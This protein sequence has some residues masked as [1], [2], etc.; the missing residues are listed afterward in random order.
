M[1]NKLC[2]ILLLI[3][4][5][6][7]SF[8]QSIGKLSIDTIDLNKKL[9]SI[10]EHVAKNSPGCAVTIIENGK[11]I[12]RRSYGMANIENQVPFTHQ[13][14]LRMPYSEARE[15]IS[16]ALVLM[17]KDGILSLND[18]VGKYYPN[19]PNWSESV[20]L[21][22]LLNHRSGFVDEWATL[23]LMY[24][25][26]SNRFETDQFLR[27]LYN[28]SIP[29]VEPGKG[30][31]YCNSDFGLLRLIME[32]ACSKD[33]PSWVSKRIFEPLKMVSTHMQKSPLDIIPNR[34]DMYEEATGNTFRQA[35]VQKT[36]PGGN[37]YI[38]TSANDLE[39]WAAAVNDSAS[40]VSEAIQKLK[41]NV[42]QI[43]GKENHFVFGY[44]YRAVGDSEVIL[45]EG[46]NGFNYL[47]RIPSKGISV[48]TLGNK[49]GDGFALENKAIINYLLNPPIEKIKMVKFLTK[50]I[51]IS[52]SELKKYTG[53]FLWQNQI[54]WEGTNKPRKFSTL[55]MDEGKLM[56][57][58]TGN[59]VL[60]LIPVG[61]DIFYYRE[62]KDGF[63]VQL[64]FKKESEGSPLVL[65]VSFDD[66][67]P[68]NSMTR[69]TDANWQ[70]TKDLLTEFT[71]RYYS[72][73]L[74][75][76]WNIGLSENGKLILKS[77]NLPDYELEA[78]GT[79]QFH[80][81]GETYPGNGFDR[82]VLFNKNDQGVITH[83]T[84]WS[85]RVMH[86]VFEK[87]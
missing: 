49:H 22:D 24:N 43:P 33:L 71:G 2:T 54:S 70:P 6:H 57:R 82:W 3:S 9:D 46:V 39:R 63:G 59:Y 17:D 21:W 66:G 81:I 42:R 50:P 7:N 11:P 27:L 35:H 40:E 62:G 87:Q 41:I 84:A 53:N 85:G 45:H 37:Y 4:F 16:I 1:R 29:E 64:E 80:Y 69:D 30:Y 25:S 51:F 34:A 56:M 13:S 5:L 31:M 32:K 65:D 8:G 58:Y 73:Q 83:L 86:H 52:E 61:N 60:K 72:K 67:Y 26:M 23:L 12:I 19:L 68:S 55:F 10:F 47:T 14:V 15:F 28:Q 76:F 38:I 48:V 44:T 36:S 74:D 75:Y 20:T 79:N 77:S 18:K 78:D